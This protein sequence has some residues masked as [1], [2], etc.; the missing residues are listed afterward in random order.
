M[1]H[2]LAEPRIAKMCRLG[3]GCDKGLFAGKHVSIT[4]AF[5]YVQLEGHSD[6]LGGFFVF[7]YSVQS[8]KKWFAKCEKHYP[9]RSE[10]TSLATPNHVQAILSTSVQGW[11][12]T[13]LSEQPCLFADLCS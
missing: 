5:Y 8:P 10:Q 1:T 3:T 11:L 7:R 13:G 2:L 12:C 4:I 6:F 9:S